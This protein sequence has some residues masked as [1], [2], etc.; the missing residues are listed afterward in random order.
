MLRNVNRFQCF[1]FFDNLFK[2]NVES[3]LFVTG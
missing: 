3:M 2:L 1:L